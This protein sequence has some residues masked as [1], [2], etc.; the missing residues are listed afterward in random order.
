MTW[1]A[2]RGRLIS[3]QQAGALPKR[4]A[5]DLVAA[6]VNDAEWGL[7]MKKVTS[8]LTLDVQGAFDAVLAKRLLQRMR[9][10]AGQSPFYEWCGISSLIAL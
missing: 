8:I 10:Q 2:L 3:P 4:A 1:S 9:L 7:A 5:T 6:F